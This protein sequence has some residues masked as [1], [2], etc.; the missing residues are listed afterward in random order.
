MNQKLVQSIN[1]FRRFIQNI[2]GG[3]FRLCISRVKV[4]GQEEI[5]PLISYMNTLV[6]NFADG[7]DFNHFPSLRNFNLISKLH[8]IE[9]GTLYILYKQMSQPGLSTS[10]RHRMDTSSKCPQLCIPQPLCAQ[11]SSSVSAP[12]HFTLSSQIG[13]LPRP[14]LLP[15]DRPLLL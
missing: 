5:F 10:G 6:G 9:L 13:P 7:E 2:T 14:Y 11:L 3:I 1:L 15:S 8:V 12:V 4:D